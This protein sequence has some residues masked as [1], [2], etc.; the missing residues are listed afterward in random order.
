MKKTLIATAVACMIAAGPALATGPLKGSLGLGLGV[1]FGNRV[2]AGSGGITEAGVA[3]R[4]RS[5][6]PGW[7]RAASRS[8]ADTRFHSDSRVVGCGQCGPAGAVTNTNGASN[9]NGEAT[10][11][12]APRDPGYAE[13]VAYGGSGGS[14]EAGRGLHVDFD[15]LLEI[16]TIREI[17]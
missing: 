5:D 12:L 17:R 2:E 6:R 11:N 13:Y 1:E 3:G 15:G 8:H 16:K 9:A 4:V 7:S 10:L 14:S